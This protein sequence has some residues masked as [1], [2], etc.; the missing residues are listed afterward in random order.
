M[1]P[2]I[3]ELVNY[4]R[5]YQ[6]TEA[7]YRGYLEITEGREWISGKNAENCTE[8]ASCE[9]KCPQKIKIVDQLKEAHAFLSNLKP[10]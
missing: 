1:I 2:E 7:A 10:E 6:L 3:F 8:C 5:V 9:E 4:H